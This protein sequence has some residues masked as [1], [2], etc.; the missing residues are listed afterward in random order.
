MLLTCVSGVHDSC[1]WSHDFEN[2]RTTNTDK[3]NG[4]AEQYVPALGA[5]GMGM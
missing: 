1:L 4:N 2:A 5:G 3:K